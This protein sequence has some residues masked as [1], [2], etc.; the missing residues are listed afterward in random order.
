MTIGRCDVLRSEE[1][2][3]KKEMEVKSSNVGRSGETCELGKKTRK[4]LGRN[5]SRF[6]MIPGTESGFGFFSGLKVC[7]GWLA[8]SGSGMVISFSWSTLTTS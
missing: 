1:E 5:R 4:S 7:S 2:K 8:F 6:G 3:V